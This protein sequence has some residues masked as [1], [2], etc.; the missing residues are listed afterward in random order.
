VAE[1]DDRGGESALRAEGQQRRWGREQLRRRGWHDG[2]RAWR[3]DDPSVGGVR[4]RDGNPRAEGTVG[5]R[6]GEGP[7]YG[8]PGRGRRR[9]RGGD[10][11]RRAQRWQAQ[12][13]GRSGRRRGRRDAPPHAEVPVV[14]R[15][16]GQ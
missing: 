16:R 12:R 10:H 9:R 7:T 14:R 1:P 15:E 8:R 13:G 5:H 3:V 4:D 11:R 2:G 6:S